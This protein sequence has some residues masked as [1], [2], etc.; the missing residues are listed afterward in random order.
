MKLEINVVTIDQA[1]VYHRKSHGLF[2][3]ERV[4]SKLRYTLSDE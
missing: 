1:K 4:N 2:T 3:F